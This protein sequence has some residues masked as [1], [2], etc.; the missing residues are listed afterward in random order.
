M[1][2]LCHESCNLQRIHHG[3]D[4][5]QSSYWTIWA[6]LEENPA[7]QGHIPGCFWPLPSVTI[8][9]G[10]LGSRLTVH[11][12]SGHLEQEWGN[13]R[14]HA[15]ASIVLLLFIGPTSATLHPG[16]RF[17]CVLAV[18]TVCHQPRPRSRLVS[19]PMPSPYWASLSQKLKASAHYIVLG[20][21]KGALAGEHAYD[22]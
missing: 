8:S 14:G 2:Y 5:G 3:E 4:C 21:C 18:E 11:A 7:S 13:H 12:G 20:L 1:G 19:L 6:T 10:Y 17:L 15:C 22:F 9:I 16:P